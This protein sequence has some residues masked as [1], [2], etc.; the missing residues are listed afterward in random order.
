MLGKQ[1]KLCKDCQ[2]LILK[3]TFVRVPKTMAH[4]SDFKKGSIGNPLERVN[5]AG[6]RYGTCMAQVLLLCAMVWYGM[7]WYGIVWYSVV[8]YGMVWKYNIYIYI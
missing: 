1:Q 6:R 3:K 2:L 7:V 5:G 8:W 4:V